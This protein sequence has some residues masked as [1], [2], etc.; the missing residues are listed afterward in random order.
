MKTEPAAIIG[1]IT[2]FVT[3]LLALLVAYGFDIDQ[4]QQSAILGLVAVVAPVVAGVAIRFNVY[5]PATVEKVEQKAYTK[6][7]A[8]PRATPVGGERRRLA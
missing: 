2:A 4:A 6:G 5:A 7:L 3:A 8:V 1:G